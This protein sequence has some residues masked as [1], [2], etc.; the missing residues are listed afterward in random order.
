MSLLRSLD[1]IVHEQR[2][3]GTRPHWTWCEH[4]H[5]SA[6]WLEEDLTVVKN[7]PITCLLCLSFAATRTASSTST[8]MTMV[9]R[10]T[11]S[12]SGS[13]TPRTGKPGS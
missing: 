1:G 7:A 8:T 2:A 10:P 11:P 4:E 5:G 9:Q 6:L 12:A 13:T 3:I